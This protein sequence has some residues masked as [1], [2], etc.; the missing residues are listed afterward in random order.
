MD[1]WVRL[2]NIT[3]TLYQPA[4]DYNSDFVKRAFGLIWIILKLVLLVCV[5]V[6]NETVSDCVTYVGKAQ[7]CQT[8]FCVTL[9]QNV[10][11]LP[12]GIAEF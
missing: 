5:S 10:N 6:M 4:A 12:V 2:E 7:H 9:G 1:S 3:S 8:L 11:E